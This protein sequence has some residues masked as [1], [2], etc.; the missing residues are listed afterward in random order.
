MKMKMNMKRR[1][2]SLQGVSPPFLG[3]KNVLHVEKSRHPFL[4]SSSFYRLNVNKD[5][6]VRGMF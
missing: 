6:A 5:P 1:T 3:V 2:V 4:S